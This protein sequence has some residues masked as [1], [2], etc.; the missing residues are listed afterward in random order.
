MK[1]TISI[2]LLLISLLVNL[3]GCQKSPINGDL[4]GHWQVM[5]VTPTPAEEIITTRMYMGFYLHVCQLYYV[6]GGG[7]NTGNMRYEGNKLTLDFPYAI[8]NE[9]AAAMM[10]QYG[11]NSNPVTF[12][13]ET[14][15]KDKMVLRDGETVVELRKY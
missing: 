14:L 6:D 2:S 1:K 5:K 15:T 7:W 8:D 10:R 3:N 13:I 9:T 11:I 12:T 4:D